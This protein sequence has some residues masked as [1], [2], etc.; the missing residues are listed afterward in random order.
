MA[1]LG[2]EAKGALNLT[3]LGG[4][5]LDFSSPG[6]AAKSEYAAMQG[7]DKTI[8][9]ATAKQD[10]ELAK[11]QEQIAK[12]R[13][14]QAALLEKGAKKDA[15]PE[16]PKFS[17]SDIQGGMGILMALA[18]FSGLLSRQPLT[19]S[20]N[21][22][23]GMVE[24]VNKGDDA[25]YQRSFKEYEANTKKVIANNQQYLAE[26][27][28]ALKSKDI[29]I[30][31]LTE[32]VRLI[33]HK[34]QNVIGQAA[35]QKQDLAGVIDTYQKV[36]K[37]DL[38]LKSFNAKVDNYN[39]TYNLRK[40][41]IEAQAA[42]QDQFGK[43]AGKLIQQRDTQLAAVAAKLKDMKPEAIQ[44][45]RQRIQAQFEKSL[46]DLRALHPQGGAPAAAAP[47]VAATSDIPPGFE[48]VQ[49]ESPGD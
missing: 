41:A 39:K 15:M 27:E 34:W 16:A 32:E 45:E 17:H 11:P 7:I 42:R 33:Q 13:G 40:A 26:M 24:G 22:M 47:A 5:A 9:E 18:A 12:A 4:P 14:E 1:E 37:G 6:S 23:A 46:A 8:A 49:F 19:A 35:A 20:M 3:S 21:A 38:D 36:K 48:E 29:G 2:Q 10:V 25:T 30:S 44:A 43:D 31:Q 28:N